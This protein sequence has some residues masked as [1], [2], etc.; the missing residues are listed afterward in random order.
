MVPVLFNIPSESPGVDLKLL[1]TKFSAT[2]GEI[3]AA[4]SP[5]E[6]SD[7]RGWCFHAVMPVPHIAALMRATA[8]LTG[9]HSGARESASPES[10]TTAAEYGFRTAAS[11]RPE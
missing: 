7:I 3:N 5:D 10:I 9:C 8:A 6:R 4:S 2:C 11:R 1:S